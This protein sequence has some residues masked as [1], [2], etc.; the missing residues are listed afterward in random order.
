MKLPAARDPYFDNLKFVLIACV[1]AGHALEPLIDASPIAHAIYNFIYFFHIPLFVF[2]TGYFSKQMDKI[3]GLVVLYL[4]FETLYTLMG[5][6]LNQRDALRFTYL[7]PYWV[8]WYLLAAIIWKVLLPYMVR[9]RFPIVSAFL[10]A[11]LA[12]YAD[13]EIGYHLSAL[14]VVTFLPFFL[15]GY[16]AKKEPLL[17]LAR[18][19]AKFASA[20]V[21]AAA[22]VL[23]Y[24]YVDAF[25]TEWLW[26]SYSYESIGFPQW[27]AGLYRVAAY[28]G[29]VMISLAVLILIPRRMTFFSDWGSRTMYPFLL[30]GFL[31]KYLVHVRLFGRI[32]AIW[33]I[34]ILLA[35]SV[36]LTAILSM[37]WTDRVLVRLFRPRLSFLVKPP[38]GNK[39]V[40]P[41]N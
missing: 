41:V 40:P 10:I 25:K 16:Y 21:M 38:N 15:A 11:V 7:T 9:L 24:V 13:K 32:D 1:V 37:P 20:A 36:M 17:A 29:S 3:G 30:H 23:L 39:A 5:Y 12:G 28:A 33:E 35:A 18:P 4:V 26:G 2:V 6:I 14:R 8:T 31:I 27:Y 19:W 34:I 22:L